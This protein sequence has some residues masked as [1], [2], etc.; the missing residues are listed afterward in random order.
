MYEKR[1]LKRK[2]HFGNGLDRI[3]KEIIEKR[4]CYVVYKEITSRIQWVWLGIELQEGNKDIY[5]GCAGSVFK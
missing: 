1:D 3:V 4:A 5:W 2:G